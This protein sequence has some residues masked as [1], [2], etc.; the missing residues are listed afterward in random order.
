MEEFSQ[1]KEEGFTPSIKV[2]EF[3]ITDIVTTD[4]ETSLAS[5]DRCSGEPIAQNALRKGSTDVKQDPVT[6]STDDVETTAAGDENLASISRLR[7]QKSKSTT[8]AQYAK[9]VE[10]LEEHPDIA[11]G[12]TKSN[13]NTF[14]K[15]CATK[16]NILGPP[17]KDAAGWKKVWFDWKSNLKRK[18][19]HNKREQKAAG[20]DPN[21]I[22][23][24]TTLE[25]RAVQ[26]AGL[27]PAVEGID[28]CVS[29]GL[30]STFSNRA[31]QDRNSE[32]SEPLH[33]SEDVEAADVIPDV[34]PTPEP[35][36]VPR[37]NENALILLEQQ[38][39]FDED[40]L[41]VLKQQTK[42]IEDLAYY[43]KQV[44]KR[45]QE[46]TNLQAEQLQ[47]Q[48]RHNLAM[49]KIA[50]EKLKA[51]KDFIDFQTKNMSQ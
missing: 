9:L 12:F 29:Y 4:E 10:L 17:V 32:E 35:G 33:P 25:E 30:P 41:N 42:K 3:I 11:K 36:S 31:I 43:N 8:K 45:L 26:L 37:L 51:K 23:E 21:K 38:Q 2:E 34:S 15:N 19:A 1:I 24:L 20:G 46:M 44:T 22:I 13:S 18:L 27:A 6:D 48:R 7:R 16:L 47:E 40:L 14:W 28:G 5:S 50:M 49:E 39:L